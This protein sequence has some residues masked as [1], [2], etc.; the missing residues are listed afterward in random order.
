MARCDYCGSTILLGG[1]RSGDLRF[2]NAKCQQ[3]GQM[4][5]ASRQIPQDVVEKHLWEIHQGACPVCQGRG[6]IDVHTSHKVW[7]ALLLTSWSSQP[8]VSCRSCGVKASFRISC[9]RSCSAG[10]AF[11][12]AWS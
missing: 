1:A 5:V 4:L 3:N 6:P 11:P 7:S 9:S 8:Q 12:G 2:C 10:G